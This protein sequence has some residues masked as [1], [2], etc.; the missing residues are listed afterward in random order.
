MEIPQK[1]LVLIEKPQ[2]NALQI[3]NHRGEVTTIHLATEY[4]HKE[5]ARIYGE[6]V[7]V[8]KHLSDKPIRYFQEERWKP[9][10]VLYTERNIDISDVQEGDRIYFHYGVVAQDLFDSDDV[11]ESNQRVKG[12]LYVV[13]PNQVFCVVKKDG[14]IIPIGGK[15]LVKPIDNDSEV[16][17]SSGLILHWKEKGKRREAQKGIVKAIGKPLLGS[18]FEIEVS[19]GDKVVFTKNSDFSNKIEGEELFV[20]DYERDVIAI[21]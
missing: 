5:Y 12:L 2:E 13:E 20:M 19:V 11:T 3:E 6:V 9:A 7:A 21:V 14:T 8:P 16:L 1:F 15:L 4:S 17:S 18:R 10:E